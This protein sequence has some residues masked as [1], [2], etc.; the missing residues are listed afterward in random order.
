MLERVNREL[1]RRT[2]VARVFPNYESLL[3]LIGSILM[4][5]NEVGVTGRRCLS[6]ERERSLTRAGSENLQKERYVI[7]VVAKIEA[8]YHQVIQMNM[9]D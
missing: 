9:V 3:R 6:N 1:K 2:M 7:S 4:D 5:I 8:C